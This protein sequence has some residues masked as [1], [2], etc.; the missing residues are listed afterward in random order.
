MATLCKNCGAPVI[1][2][3]KTQKVVCTVCGGAWEAEEIEATDK[4]FEEKN[5]A[6]SMNDVY[7]NTAK[8]FMDC[9]IY[10]CGSCGGEIV[11]NGSEVSTK[12]IYCG[13]TS[14]VFNRISKEKAPEFI[15]PFSISKEEA[16]EQINKTFSK[17]L[18]VPKEIKN[19]NPTAVRG[20]YVPYWIVNGLHSEADLISGRRGNGKSSHSVYCGRAGMMGITN[21]PVDASLMLSDESSQ[22]L[23]PY[24]LSKLKYF[25][26]DYLLGF[27]SNVSDV[28]NAD[29][30][31]AV[32]KRASESFQNKAMESFTGATGKKVHFSRTATLINRDVFYAMLPVWFVTFDYQ[33][34]HNTIMVNGQTGKVV[35]GVPWSKK[36]Y[37]IYFAILATLLSVLFS[38]GFYA[39][40]AHA[41]VK[42]AGSLPTL[43]F[44]IAM[45][46]LVPVLIG[47]AT[48]KK[49]KTQ[50]GRSQSESIFN[51]AKKRQE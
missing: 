45:F 22:R 17:R 25:D 36:V 34:K 15:L 6:V 33:G 35:G 47:A 29:L 3:P 26:E 8:E 38:A 41:E 5:R 46:T 14:V 37:G 31:E 40:T 19:L 48:M 11:I 21:L 30:Y 1:F 50:L 42:E 44:V 13:S 9:Y 49:L 2:D 39:A 10:T 24:D 16:L 12:C 23:E 32:N 28:T 4:G 18:F 27:Y 7:G 43:L 51:F 20:I